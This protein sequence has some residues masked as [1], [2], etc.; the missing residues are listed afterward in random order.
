MGTAHFSSGREVYPTLLTP[1]DTLPPPFPPPKE[2]GSKDTLP[3]PRGQ[4]D[5]RLWKPSIPQLRWW[6]VMKRS[7][8]TWLVTALPSDV[9][10]FANGMW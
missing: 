1:W 7:E 10:T 6:T 3:H 9:I 8:Y 2:Y 4:N 5:T